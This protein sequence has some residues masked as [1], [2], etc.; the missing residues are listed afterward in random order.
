MAT[1]IDIANALLRGKGD[2]GSGPWGHDGST[3][4]G[5]SAIGS[6]LGSSVSE[7]RAAGQ[8]PKLPS[9]SRKLFSFLS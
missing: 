3:G 8:L 1:L 7:R 9:R 2:Q 6:Y 4:G 5:L